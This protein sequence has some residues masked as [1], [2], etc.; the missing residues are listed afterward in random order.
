MRKPPPEDAAIKP[1]YGAFA[2]SDQ[3]FAGIA[4]KTSQN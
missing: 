4:G 2:L 3:A 1:S